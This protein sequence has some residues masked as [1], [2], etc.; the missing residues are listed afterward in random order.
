MEVAA[1]DGAARTGR[2][3]T[4]RGS[5][6][7]PAFMPVG[8]R[9]TVKA[10]DSSDLEVLG[11]D[12]VLANAYHLMLRPGV[13]TVAARRAP[14]LFWLDRPYIDRLGGLS[15]PLTGPAVDD[16]G[17]TFASVYDGARIRI[18]P[19][20][21]VEAPGADRRRHPD[22]A[23]RVRFTP[24]RAG[25][26]AGGR[27]PYR[28]LGYPCPPAPPQQLDAR[29]RRTGAVRHRPG[30]HR[31]G[32]R[33]ES[34]LRTAELDFDGY[35]VGGLSVGEPRPAMLEALAATVPHLPPDRPRYLMGVGDPSD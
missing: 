1:L 13:D 31:P 19:E 28:G 26:V 6:P 24:R 27:R 2:V 14:P 29:A 33:K 32:L 20:S 21:A 5:Y 23:R 34:A 9:G 3:H 35:G 7:T 8:T 16:D 12:V 10:L 11:A 30:R 25:G 15:G 22:G 4:A 17:V 18:T